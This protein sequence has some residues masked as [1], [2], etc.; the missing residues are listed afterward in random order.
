MR[1]FSGSCAACTLRV[2]CL[3]PLAR[4]KVRK[5]FSLSE[6]NDWSGIFTL[7]HGRVCASDCRII[8]LFPRSKSLPFQRSKMLA[9]LL[10]SRCLRGV[11]QLVGFS[12]WHGVRVRCRALPGKRPVRSLPLL[13]PTAHSLK[14]RFPKK[15]KQKNKP[16]R[17]QRTHEPP[18]RSRERRRSPPGE[19]IGGSWE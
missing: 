14:T 9:L 19:S 15:K 12:L 16:H 13:S 5:G 1:N 8:S 6:G 18:R 4:C 3:K 10:I 11:L 17:S 7:L 2:Q